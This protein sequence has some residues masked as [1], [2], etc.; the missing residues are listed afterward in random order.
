M[1]K[2]M[3]GMVTVCAKLQ[4]CTDILQ[5]PPVLLSNPKILLSA[6]GGSTVIAN[7]I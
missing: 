3:V 5:T 4:E 6:Q 7:L 2:Y 1:H